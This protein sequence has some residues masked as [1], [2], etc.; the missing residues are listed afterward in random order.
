MTIDQLATL[1]P[2]EGDG[3]HVGSDH[4]GGEVP[5]DLACDVCGITENLEGLSPIGIYTFSK[6]GK[7]FCG[8]CLRKAAL[9]AER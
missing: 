6:L 5:T 3:W 8:E 2:Q 1:N 9:V 7:A 4:D